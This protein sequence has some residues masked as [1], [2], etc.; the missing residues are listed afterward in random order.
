MSVL[1]MLVSAFTGFDAMK[2]AYAHTI[3]ATGGQSGLLTRWLS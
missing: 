1:F 3:L 2:Q